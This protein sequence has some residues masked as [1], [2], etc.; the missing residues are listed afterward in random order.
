MFNLRPS[1]PLG[2][3][4]PRLCQLRTDGLTPASK[5]WTYRSYAGFYGPSKPSSWLLTGAWLK[6]TASVVM[7]G[8]K[9]R[10]VPWATQP[11]WEVESGALFLRSSAT[12][13][14]YWQLIKGCYAL[15]TWDTYGLGP[16][17][18]W[19]WDPCGMLV[20]FSLHGVHRFKSSRLSDMSNRLFTG[21]SM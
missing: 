13:Q 19:A 10:W 15:A 2:G 8:E 3:R 4:S 16:Y 9:L 17:A 7:L 20:G 18:D 5:Y 21:V 11:D 1:G 14:P 12:V 6:R